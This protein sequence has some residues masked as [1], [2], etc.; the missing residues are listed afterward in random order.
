MSD[1]NASAS[2][3]VAV[4]LQ[5]VLQRVT[6][7][8]TKSARPTA[9]LVAVSKTKPAELVMACYEIG[10]RHFGENYIQELEEKA[11]LLQ[12]TCPDLKW[13]F[14]GRIQSNKI[15]KICQIPNLW[16]VETIDNKD[17]FN[18]SGEQNKGGIDMA[19]API[20]ADHVV[21][22]CPDLKLIG[23][24]TIGSID[25]SSKREANADFESLIQIRKSV[26]EKLDKPEETMELSMGMSND[27]ELAIE[28]GSTNIR[29]GSSI[30]GA[31]AYPP[32]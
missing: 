9:R 27:F 23:L 25:E 13:H 22:N 17:H 2:A 5:R 24:M 11:N 16:C 28:Y 12:T 15:K 30:F 19:E 6:D 29:V 4:N 3:A 18:T 14:I 20:L 32:K 8:A 26:C 31:R 10:H 21:K 7:L 1:M